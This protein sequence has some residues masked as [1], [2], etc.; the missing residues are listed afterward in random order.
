LEADLPKDVIHEKAENEFA[1]VPA[2][3]NAGDDGGT[4]DQSIHGYRIGLFCFRCN[5]GKG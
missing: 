1:G 2:H 3:P 4:E 5:V